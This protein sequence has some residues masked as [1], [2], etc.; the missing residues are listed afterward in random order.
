MSD[1]REE[2]R[3]ILHRRPEKQSGQQQAQ[4]SGWLET[5]LD[6]A[7]TLAVSA[8]EGAD[9]RTESGT[10]LGGFL[11]IATDVFDTADSSGGE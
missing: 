6:V 7:G 3:R 8:L 10:C 1:P 11:K 2:M 5:V 4:D 9:H